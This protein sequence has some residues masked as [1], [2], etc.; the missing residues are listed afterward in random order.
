MRGAVDRFNIH[1]RD[2]GSCS[3][4][5]PK[6]TESLAERTAAFGSYEFVVTRPNLG[7]EAV[8]EGNLNE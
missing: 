8:A 1:V 7:R 3:A 5:P 6:C 4:F 2:G